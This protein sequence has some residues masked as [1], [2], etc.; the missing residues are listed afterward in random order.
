[1]SDSGEL[2]VTG[3]LAV[4]GCI[5]QSLPVD[6]TAVPAPPV[7]LAAAPSETRGDSRLRTEDIEV[8]LESL[9]AAVGSATFPCELPSAASARRV[10]GYSPS[11]LTTT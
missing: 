7:D 2:R 4:Y 10:R 6:L 5:G 9:R 1:M 3:G 11:S 8:A